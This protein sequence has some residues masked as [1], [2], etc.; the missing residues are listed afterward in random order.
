MARRKRY[1]TD[2]LVGRAGKLFVAAELHRRGVFASVALTRAPRRNIV[3]TSP[4]GSR[5]VTIQVKTK[6]PHSRVW[7]WN[8]QRAEQERSTP[9]GHFMVL[10][11]LVP[12]QPVYYVWPLRS[13]ANQCYRN[14]HAWLASIGG[15]YPRTPGS[16]Q[17]RIGIADIET[18]KDAWHLLGV[19]PGKE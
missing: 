5:T 2:E 16:Q 18:G 1:R 10:V 11:D 7:H 9:A 6:R 8:V 12:S 4:D 17:I 14:H 19:I 13:L 15:E 3:A